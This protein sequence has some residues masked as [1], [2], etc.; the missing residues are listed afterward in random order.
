MKDKV[1]L[2]HVHAILIRN[3]HRRDAYILER[4]QSIVN[5]TDP[6]VS[7]PNAQYDYKLDN[8]GE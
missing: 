6:A 5:A 3:G 8:K 2:Q 1:F 4:L 7:T